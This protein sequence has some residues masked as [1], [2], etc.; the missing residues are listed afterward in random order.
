[1][2]TN[3]SI[4]VSGSTGNQGGAVARELLGSGHHVR[5][6]SRN[7]GSDAA[8]ALA[9]LGAEVVSGDFDDDASLRRAADGVDAV[10]VM[11]TP[12]GTDPRTETRQSIGLIDAADGQGV[13]HIVYTSV[14]SALDDTGIPHFES[15]ALVERHLQTLGGSHTVVAPAAFLGDL[16]SPWFMPG[17]LEGRYAFALPGDVPLQ[18]VALPDIAAFVALVLENRDRFAGERVELASAESTGAQVAAK[19]TVRLGREVRYEETPLQAVRDHLGDDGV[20]MIEFFR[21]GGYTIDIPELHRAYPEVKWHDLDD[22]IG[23]HDWSAVR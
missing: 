5:A 22:W 11:G 1:M 6:L 16:T 15:K 20:K 13:P 8:Q 3:L 14:A 18:Q 21:S 4:L 12:F 7:P 10:F 19:L 17:L 9:G 23:S 2:S